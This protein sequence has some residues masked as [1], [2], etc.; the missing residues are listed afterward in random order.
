[1]DIFG[2]GSLHY[3]PELDSQ[4]DPLDTLTGYLK[5]LGPT[6]YGSLNLWER[7][8]LDTSHWLKRTTSRETSH[9]K[10]DRYFLVPVTHEFARREPSVMTLF[11]TVKADPIKLDKHFTPPPCFCSSSKVSS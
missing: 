11:G 6:L 7:D 4:C 9:I 2:S 8:A 10:V 1:V 3:L 5:L